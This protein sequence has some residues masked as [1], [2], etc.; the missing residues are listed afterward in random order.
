MTYDEMLK[1]AESFLRDGLRILTIP[2][3][4]QYYNN[5]PKKYL[6]EE[7]D[8]DTLREVWCPTILAFNTE[9]YNPGW[10]SKVSPW[11]VRGTRPENDGAY[12]IKKTKVPVDVREKYG[13]II[14]EYDMEDIGAGQFFATPLSI[15]EFAVFSGMSHAIPLKKAGKT[16]F[17]ATPIFLN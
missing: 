15:E 1:K 10:D 9:A 8:E 16:L 3:V 11:C 17:I 2:E 12:L 4:V 14:D 5:P 7:G 13:S 6:I